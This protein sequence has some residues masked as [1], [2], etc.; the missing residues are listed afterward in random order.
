MKFLTS[1]IQTMYIATPPSELQLMEDMRKELKKINPKL[2]ILF[3]A[4]VS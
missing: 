2:T 3:Q 1:K 4:D